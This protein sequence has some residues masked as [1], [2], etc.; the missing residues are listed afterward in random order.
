MI[1]EMSVMFVWN[2]TPRVLVLSGTDDEII[3]YAQRN[4]RYEAVFMYYAK[5][6]G[7]EERIGRLMRIA[8]SG[9]MEV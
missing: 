3:N 7:R 5:E 2:S 9:T 1:E 8:Y 4:P 6:Y